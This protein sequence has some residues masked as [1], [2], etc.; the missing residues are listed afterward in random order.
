MT[1][2]DSGGQVETPEPVRES[3]LLVVIGEAERAV[4]PLRARL[5]DAAAVQIPAH[6]TV[7]WPFLPANAVDQPVLDRLAV[8]FAAHPSFD[9][10]FERTAWFGDT[11][12]WLAPQPRE[13][14]VELTRAVWDAY[15]QC[16]P[17]RGRHAGEH[18]H[19]TIGDRRPLA[20]LVQAERTVM[21]LLPIS[22]RVEQVTLMA[23]EAPQ[24]SWAVLTTFALA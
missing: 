14:F 7:L 3:A 24:G 16:P 15:P 22:A 20:E 12:L 21:P 8:L 9:V 13:P 23:Q 2:A 6:V 5:D 11:V 10:R 17:Y 19:L 1:P 4:G 18:P